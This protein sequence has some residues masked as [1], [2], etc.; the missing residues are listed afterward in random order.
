MYASKKNYRDLMKEIRA[1]Y[2]PDINL[3]KLPKLNGKNIGG[4]WSLKDE[5]KMLPILSDYHKTNVISLPVTDI[6]YMHFVTWEGGFMNLKKGLFDTMEPI[7][8]EV[9]P[10]VIFVPCLAIDKQGNRIGYGGGYYDKYLEKH[11]KIHTIALVYK[12]QV[13]DEELPHTDK[14]VKIKETIIIDK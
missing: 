13:F 5:I 1:N 10:D 4:Y 11:P 2:S 7:G 9:V 3:S 12:F 8:D 14:D 6:E